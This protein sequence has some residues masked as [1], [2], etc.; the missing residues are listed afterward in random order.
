VRTLSALDDLFL[1][2]ESPR[3]PMHVCGVSLFDA[4]DAAEPY[5][6]GRVRDVIASRLHLVPV[7]RRRVVDA[8][9]GVE[10]ARWIEDPD[11][12]IDRHVR[13]ATVRGGLR[14][15]EAFTAHVIARPLDR[16]RPLWKMWIVEGLDAGRVACVAK[17]HHA[18][19]DG[20]S[21]AEITVNL[22]DFTREPMHVAPPREP[23]KPEPLP[24][25]ASTCIWTAASAAARPMRA[26]TAVPRLAGA[27][28]RAW[29]RDRSGPGLPLPF[30]A[31]R[32]PLN[33]T[34]GTGR[35]I[36]FA[37]LDLDTVKRVK[38]A[39]GVKVNDVVLALSAGALRRYLGQALP[40]RPLVAMVPRSVRGPDERGA[41]GNRL[42][43]MLC[44]L[45]T[46]V[47]DPLRRLRG[48]ADGARE[49]KTLQEALGP[50]AFEEACGVIHPAVLRLWS[51]SRLAGGF[52]P[53]FNVVVSNIAGSP[54]PLYSLGAPMLAHYPL[55]PVWDGV[56]LNITVMSYL[57]S[58]DVG[59]LGERSVDVD[60]VAD[61]LRA[62][63]DE[64]ERAVI[65]PR[66]DGIR[67]AARTG[68]RAAA[69]RAGRD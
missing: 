24:S 6:F 39:M 20:V 46:D 56:G 50:A 66:R 21:G 67:V 44:S 30:A 10:R 32:T 65:P 11:F 19:I 68:H 31:P 38:D 23:W 34:L 13:P 58:L 55:G 49:A 45:A 54:F 33:T 37:S 69:V 8:P 7:F 17:I 36:A 5:T 15:L 28:L 14:E 4:A 47:D 62:S 25:L 48:I 29:R 26:A 12:D 41:M 64:L 40:D 18:A 51:A 1:R 53:M 2:I 52:R 27:A 22:L 16:S 43:T 42:A 3:L 59:V 60:A 61:A 57:A 35:R 9:F 63:L